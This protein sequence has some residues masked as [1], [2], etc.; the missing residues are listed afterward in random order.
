MMK[1]RWNIYKVLTHAWDEQ[2]KL[3]KV[4]SSFNTQEEAIQWLEE[5]INSN[6]LV[7]FGEYTILPIYKLEER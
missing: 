6:N 3:W 1:V 7:Y 5:N 4:G 2:A